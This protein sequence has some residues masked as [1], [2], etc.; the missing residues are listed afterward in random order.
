MAS[1][2]SSRARKHPVT[3]AQLCAPI[4]RALA[5]GPVPLLVLRLPQ[6]ECIAWRDGK[7]VAQR[8]ERSATRAFHSAALRVLRSGDLTAHDPGS[9]RFAIAMTAPSR[10]AG[11]PSAADCRAVLERVAAALSLNA[12]L[13]VETG[14]TTLRRLDAC[15]G[16]S[17]DI[18][19]ALERGARERERYEFFAAIGHELRTP[20]T[21]IRGYLETLLEGEIE[22][23]VARRFLETSRREALRMGRLLDGMFEFSLL[24]LSVDALAGRSCDVARQIELA[25]EV[26]CPSALAR[27]IVVQRITDAQAMA[28]IDPDACLQLLVNLLDNGIKYGAEAGTV[29]IGVGERG[30][31]LVVTVD[32]DGPGIAA[33]ERESIFGL[34]VRGAHAAMRPGTGIGLAIVKMIVERVGGLIRVTESPLGGARFEASLPK[35]ELPERVS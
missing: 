23:A 8:L 28:A 31:E 19:L 11:P 21:S 27:G 24:D 22:P 9:D 26:V 2:T 4:G 3:T 5:N 16:L 1:A 6:F 20:L 7:R 18:E 14:W 29:A 25:C 35:A 32:D 33:G 12:E 34:R 10:H 13:R 17:H 30:A 15:E